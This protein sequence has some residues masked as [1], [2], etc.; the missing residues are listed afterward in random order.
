MIQTET[1]ETKAGEIHLFFDT[2]Q[3]SYLVASDAIE[4]FLENTQ[5]AKEIEEAE[6]QGLLIHLPCKPGEIVYQVDKHNKKIA[7]KII[8]KIEV[9]IQTSGNV[10]MLIWFND[11]SYCLQTHFG[12][13]VFK[14]KTEAFAALDHFLN[15]ENT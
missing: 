5:K 6:K 13:T 3:Q 1:R 15:K 8:S 11:F 14:Q 4:L 7:T 2:E 12:K 10:T 9:T